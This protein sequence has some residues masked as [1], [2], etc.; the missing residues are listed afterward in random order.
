[1]G[2]LG[3]NSMRRSLV[4][5]HGVDVNIQDKIHRTPLHVAS[6]HW[7]LEIAQVS[8]TA[9]QRMRETILAGPHYTARRN[10]EVTLTRKNVASVLHG[11][12]W[13]MGRISTR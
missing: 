12:Y 1:M 7:S 6:F 4:L 11:Y 2:S 3:E 9:Q 8:T 13:S 10:T 5:E